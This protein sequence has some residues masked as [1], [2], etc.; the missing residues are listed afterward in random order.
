V[1]ELRDELRMVVNRLLEASEQ[2][3]EVTLDELGDALG[4]LSASYPEIDA[5]IALL[6]AQARR[7]AAPAGGSGEAH[8]VRVVAAAKALSS[9][10]GRRPSVAEIA[11]LAG[12]TLEQV[13]HAL[14]LA[15]IMQR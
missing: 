14:V 11:P 1:T 7:V 6:E 5:M 3:R 15:R 2:S 8:L 9:Q 4:T 12:L 10:L 13:R